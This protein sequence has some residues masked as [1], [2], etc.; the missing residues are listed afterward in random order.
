MRESS[1]SGQ[2]LQTLLKSF[3]RRMADFSKGRLVVVGDIGLDEYVLGDVRRISP[4][5]PVPVLEVQTEDARLGLA[6]N[7]AQN[8]AS[9]GGV[10]HMVAVV[11][12]D[13]AA[14]TLR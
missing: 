5:A 13:G 7:V 8:V 4:E 14:D 2:E 6:S 3:P 1:F 12:E 9:L 11:G 10:A